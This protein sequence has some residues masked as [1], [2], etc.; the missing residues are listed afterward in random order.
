MSSGSGRTGEMAE[1]TTN[2]QSIYEQLRPLFFPR[3]IA[4]V[5]VSRDL[6]KTGTCMVRSLQ[7]FG[8][9][10]TL[11]PIGRGGG[12]LL[13][14]DV[15]PSVLDVPGP[16]DLACLFIPA[17]AMVGTLR[18]CR[19]K[20]VQ[21][22]IA[23]TSGLSETGTAEGKALE[24]DIA[25]ELDGTFR[26]VG[27]NC[28]GLYSPKG[29]VTQHPGEGYARE[30]GEV[31]FVAQSGG[32]SED[33]ARAAPN[34]GFYV[35]KLVSY[36]NAID[37]NEADLLEYMEAD[38]D[39]RIIGMYIEG[40][41]NGRKFVDVLRRVAPKKPVVV[42]KG[43]LTPQGAQAASSHTG[44]LAGSLQ[45]WKAL[46]HQAGAVQ[47][48]SQEEQ[49]DALSAFHFLPG[50]RDLR[51]GYVCAGGGNSVAAADASYKAGLTLPHVSPPVR[52]AIAAL[53]PPV[54]STAS[55]PV[56]VLAPV[57]T[58]PV[59]RGVMEAMAGSAEVGAIILDKIVM[60][61]ELR[62]LECYAEQLESQDE[63]WLSDIPI[64]IK[65]TFGLPVIVVLRENLDPMR[66]SAI[67]AERLRLRKYYQDNGIA[68]YPTA[69]RAFRALGH[70][71]EYYRRLEAVTGSSNDD[72]GDTADRPTAATVPAADAAAAK[73]R[74]SELIAAARAEGRISL[75]EHEAKQVLAVYGIPVTAERLI[76]SQEELRGSLQGF[77]FP[78]VLKID[79]PDI[80]HKTEAGLVELDCRDADAAEK[81]FG[82]LMVRAKER[83]PD[84]RING[85]LVQEWVSAC[86]ECIVGLKR[87]PQFGPTIMFGLGGIFV[88]VFGDV[89]LRV[90]PLSRNDAAEMI[91]ET[92]GY[93][94]LAGA[95]GRPKADVAAIEDVLLKMSRLALD[96][97]TE[98]AEIDINPLMVGVE[99]RSV[100]AADA[101]ILLDPVK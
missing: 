34:F 65:D 54:G 74:A 57:P 59:I 26:L 17:V 98:V 45:I 44:S 94:I 85:V 60:S 15:Y 39:T 88:E 2:E 23:F 10:G 4:V 90:A 101:L 8:F 20:G 25:S 29:G 31:A 11:Y 61:T 47:V 78:V 55:N 43:G 16:I 30:S 97:E 33:F 38:P 77:S 96:L 46:L 14:L 21:A 62:R 72:V 1:A 49:L 36:G 64:Q 41:R 37:V 5:G 84:A 71:V 63:P 86:A 73:R 24:V 100:K 79:S 83:Y 28:L 76:T 67:E 6:W 93:K 81:A 53:L 82:R 66:G 91:R 52:D 51:V 99:G 89:A 58:A 13:G 27:P 95:R 80:L 7:R 9:P 40:P 3:S 68:V 32:L 42:W 48:D 69:E 70:V 22:V 56:D 50:H 19:E 18:E 12:Q 87:D 35:S 75:S 92:K